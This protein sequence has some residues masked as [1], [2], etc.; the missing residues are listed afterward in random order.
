MKRKVSDINLNIKRDQYKLS[1]LICIGL[2][3]GDALGATS[4][5]QLPEDVGANCVAAYSE[6]NWPAKLAGGGALHWGQG[7]PTDDTDM[8]MCI[9]KSFVQQGGKFDPV[10]IGKEFVSWMRAGPADIGNLTQTTLAIVAR[11]KFIFYRG[12]YDQ[13]RKKPK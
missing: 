11:P 6:Y 2:A 9:L 1:A 8:A 7:E 4:E 13:W 5:F 12:A 3:V 10:D